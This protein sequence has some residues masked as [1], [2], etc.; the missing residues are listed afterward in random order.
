MDTHDDNDTTLPQSRAFVTSLIQSL[1]TSQTTTTST[2]TPQANP[3]KQASPTDRSTLLT[4][5]VLFPNELLSALDLLDRDLV[6]RFLPTPTPPIQSQTGRQTESTTSEQEVFTLSD[7]TTTKFKVDKD[8]KNAVYYVR[9]A[10]QTSS[11]SRFRDPVAASTHYEVRTSSWSCSCPAFAFSAFPA[12]ASTDEEEGDDEFVAGEG[13]EQQWMVGGL[14][15]GKNVPLCK[16]LLACV[17]AER[18]GL[19]ERYVKTRMVSVEELAG[20]NAGWGG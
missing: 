20:W 7:D 13:E 15:L 10:Q 4:L 8:Y 14:S 12:N 6:V 2:A 16:H 3:L 5:H 17:L 11:N 1:N 18:G 9:S 19:F